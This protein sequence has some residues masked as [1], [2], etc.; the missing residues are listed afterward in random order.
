MLGAACPRGPGARREGGIV[1]L[2]CGILAILGG[3]VLVVALCRWTIW[4]DGWED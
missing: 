4:A 3:F 1:T 2:L